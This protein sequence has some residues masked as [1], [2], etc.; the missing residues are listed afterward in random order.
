MELDEDGRVVVQPLGA[1]GEQAPVR[2]E[3][4][5]GGK[6]RGSR[7]AGQVRITLG[8]GGRKVG[9]VGDDEIDLAGHRL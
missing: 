1:G 7:L 2:L 6:D 8:V 9:Q 3:P 5:T 4:I